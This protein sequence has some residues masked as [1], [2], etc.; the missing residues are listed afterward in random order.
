MLYALGDCFTGMLA[1][2]E[3]AALHFVW[4]RW[5]R[6]VELAPIAL[7]PG[8][9]TFTLNYDALGA[10]QGQGRF[11]LNDQLVL[12]KVSLSPTPVR[13][14]SGGLDVGIN[15][16]QPISQRIAG[17]QGF[18]Y[19]GTVHLVRLDP[20]QQAP[21]SPMVQDEAAVQASMRAA[22]KTAN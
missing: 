19:T 14:P 1:F 8:S 11:T 6:P 12:D 9:Q 20:G 16:R 5:M 18:P 21:G 10:R 4:Q 3:D 7:Q 22:A 2:V 13:L 15:R 17:R